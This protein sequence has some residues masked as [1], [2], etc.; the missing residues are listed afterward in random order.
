VRLVILDVIMP[1]KG[2][3]E[4]RSEIVGIAPE[5]RVLYITGYNA[6]ILRS[7]G[8]TEGMDNFILKPVSPMDLLR[9]VRQTLDRPAPPGAAPSP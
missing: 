9:T 5:A 8:F 1:R 3:R 7:K 6:E 4:V 2:G